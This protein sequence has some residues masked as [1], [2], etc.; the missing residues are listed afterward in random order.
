MLAFE[1]RG[2]QVEFDV[3]AEIAAQDS[4]AGY[5]DDGLLDPVLAEQRGGHT[6]VV[7]AVHELAPAVLGADDTVA[8]QCLG[9]RGA[10]LLAVEEQQLGLGL[11]EKN[12]PFD[13]ARLEADLVVA[14]LQHHEHSQG[15]APK[16]RDEQLADALVVPLVA[17]LEVG[18][19]YVAAG[20]PL[21]VLGQFVQRRL[22]THV[23]NLHRRP[24][25]SWR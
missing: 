14:R 3:L 25:V 16:D 20:G 17:P 11:L 18:K 7:A 5:R 15:M 22:E 2:G 10:P 1:V 23:I 21:Q 6:H 13:G 8:G 24:A 12:D 9:E 4:V 19:L